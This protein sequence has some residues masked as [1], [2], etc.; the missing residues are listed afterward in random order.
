MLKK[1]C[2]VI[3]KMFAQPRSPIFHAICP[4]LVRAWD[5]EGRAWEGKERWDEATLKPCYAW[6]RCP[7]LDMPWA[8]KV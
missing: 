4:G 6:E 5:G 2:A 1:L 8:P 3:G 7:G